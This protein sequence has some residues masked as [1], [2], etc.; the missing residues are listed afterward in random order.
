MKGKKTWLPVGLTCL[1]VLGAMLLPQSV[2]RARDARLLGRNSGLGYDQHRR[3]NDC[4][5]ALPRKISENGYV[6]S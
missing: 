2:S 4:R 6:T 5:N 3:K 1:V